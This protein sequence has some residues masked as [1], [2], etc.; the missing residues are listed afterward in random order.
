MY[1]WGNGVEQDLLKAVEFY[2]KAC[3]LNDP[4]GCDRYSV[5]MK[6]ILGK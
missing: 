2:K 4:Y 6:N 1:E 5:L 3:D